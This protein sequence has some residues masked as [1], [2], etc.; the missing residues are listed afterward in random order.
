MTDTG[1]IALLEYFVSGNEELNI[2]NFNCVR[3]S[4][5]RRNY[6]CV[7]LYKGKERKTIADNSNFSR[8]NSLAVQR[9]DR[10]VI[11]VAKLKK[12]KGVG[13]KKEI[14]STSTCGEA[15]QFCSIRL[16]AT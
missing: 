13:E 2:T 6:I 15:K 14:D 8:F 1:F 7:Y 5:S 3:T 12:K 4:G 16:S 10:S 9:D 11:F